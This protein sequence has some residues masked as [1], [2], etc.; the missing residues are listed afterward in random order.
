MRSKT[1]YYGSGTFSEQSRQLNFVA[2]ELVEQVFENGYIITGDAYDLPTCVLVLD[3][4]R[5]KK[6]VPQ[7]LWFMWKEE[8]IGEK[9]RVA[10]FEKA[11]QCIC[12]HF[13][14]SA[15]FGHSNLY[16]HWPKYVYP[17]F[18]I[19]N[20][21][22]EL[23]ETKQNEPMPYL[24]M[25][26]SG[27]ATMFEYFKKERNIAFSNILLD[28]KEVFALLSDEMKF[29]G[30]P[31]LP[32]N[33]SFDMG[34]WGYPGIGTKQSVQA[35]R[36]NGRIENFINLVEVTRVA[37]SFGATENGDCVRRQVS[38][39]GAFL[40]ALTAYYMVWCYLHDNEAWKEAYRRSYLNPIYLEEWKSESLD[41]DL[42]IDKAAKKHWENVLMIQELV[43]SK[44]D[45]DY[46]KNYLTDF[47]MDINTVIGFFSEIYSLS[48]SQ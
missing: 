17:Q 25:K 10:K 30:H 29:E 21:H 24:L 4:L 14:L 47:P 8:I 39:T 18:E 45:Y 12:Y 23:L 44:T 34:I 36:Q 19:E 26:R 20:I 48:A 32:E 28:E 46:Y 15:E 3:V 31:Y 38:V 2:R 35:L 7:E 43:Q 9:L 27:K 11:G 6:L 1:Y 22:E 33:P 41:G 5:W 13:G 37:L 42:L 40:E 16:W